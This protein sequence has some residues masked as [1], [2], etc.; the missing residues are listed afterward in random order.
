MVLLDNVVEVFNLADKDRHG[1]VGVD[2]V[3]GRLVGA[4]LVH[5]DFVWIAVRFHGL[6]E[7]ALRRSHVPLRRQQEVDGLAMLVGG[8][9]E[10]FPEALD[11][12]IRLVHAPAAAD[13]ALVLAGHFLISGKK[14]IAYRFIVEWSTDTPRSSIF[15]SR[16]L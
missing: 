5:R 9:V 6:V 16:C 15:S 7:E 2:L 8:A 11:V 14:R 4:T 10:V 3:R 12:D 13:R 1:A